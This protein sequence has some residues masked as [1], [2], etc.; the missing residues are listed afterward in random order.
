MAR[1]FQNF[2]GT[3]SAYP[4]QKASRP[5][6]LQNVEH[7]LINPGKTGALKMCAGQPQR[8]SVDNLFSMITKS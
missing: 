4:Y 1:P 7:Q 5:G 2:L 3:N 8:A 6:L